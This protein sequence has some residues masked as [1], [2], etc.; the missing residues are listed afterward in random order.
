MTVGLFLSTA[1]LSLLCAASALAQNMDRVVNEGTPK[2]DCAVRV[3]FDR[4]A[5][6]PGYVVERSG[7]R[8]C[9]PFMPTAQLVPPD[10]KGKDFYGNEF[11]DERIKARWAACRRDT[12]CAERVLAAAKPFVSAEKR[13]TGAVDP[14]G[15]IDPE[16][17]VDLRAIRRPAYFGKAP[18]GEP[19]ADAEPRAFT[20]EFTVPRDNYERLHLKK[21][22]P[23][24]LRG[25]YFQGAGVDDGAGRRVRALVVMNNG[26]GQEITAIDDPRSEGAVRDAAGKWVAGRFP[27]ALTEESGARHWR[28]FIHALHA[29]GFDVLVTDRRGNGLSG[30][31][32]GYNTAEQANDIFRELEQLDTG[33]GFRALAP[34][35]EVLAGRPAAEQ[36]LAG[37]RAREMPI[38]IGGYSRGSYATAWAMHKNVVED[39]SLD[40]PEGA[41]RPARGWTNIKG[42]ILYGPNSGGLGYRV[43]GHDL[44]EAALRSEFNTTYYPDG[45]VLANVGKWP[46]LQVVRGTWDYV[47]GLEGSF[48]AYNRASGFKDIFVFLGPHALNTQ[49]PENMRL[50][51]ERMAAFAKAAVLG[52]K[53]VEGAAPPKD[54]RELVA[55]SP[56]HWE[57]T[58]APRE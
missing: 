15:R 16:G 30:G 5:D 52:R 2:P 27:D 9:L 50:A 17:E 28:G 46:G 8:A 21:D 26:G 38:G 56:D 7:R 55:S 3:N 40:L 32:S 29:A 36:V 39:C 14:A 41:C 42:A 22:D 54:L 6:M 11:T 12:A 10:D 49:N 43:V 37:Q 24:K 13:D 18:Y 34:S 23:I 48:D 33:D 58:T 25:W 4:N 51:G 44:I 19:I 35:G 45:R 57:T 1:T 53:Q 20:V 31:V 47:E